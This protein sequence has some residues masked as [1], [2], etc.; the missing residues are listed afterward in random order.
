MNKFILINTEK[1]EI[2]ESIENIKSVVLK[3][4]NINWVCQ[5]TLKDQRIINVGIEYY[6]QIKDKLLSL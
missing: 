4:N 1:C 2:I 6:E 3:N 5:I